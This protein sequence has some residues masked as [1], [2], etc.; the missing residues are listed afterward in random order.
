MLQYEINTKLRIAAFIAQLAHESGCFRYVRELA[1]GKAYE[2]R[3]DLGNTVE[4]DG[5]KFKGRGLIQIT[6][7]SNYKNAS[8]ALFNDL[9]LLSNPELLE[10][11]EY[12]VK[13]ACWFWSVWA[14]LNDEADKGDFKT[15]TKRINGGLNGWGDRKSKYDIALQIL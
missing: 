15:I 4:G 6:G 2:G 14:K 5:V 11:P 7:K 1:S 8:L 12:A 13:S 3:K 10:V 9:R